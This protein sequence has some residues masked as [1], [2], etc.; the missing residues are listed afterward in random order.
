MKNKQANIDIE[1]LQLLP[2][3]I[4]L[5]DTN[6]VY[7]INQKAI[8]LFK[9]EEQ[10]FEKIKSYDSYHFVKEPYRKKIKK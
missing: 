8:D 10:D 4:I 7:F 5:F 1:T 9:I 6:E 3:P 2:V